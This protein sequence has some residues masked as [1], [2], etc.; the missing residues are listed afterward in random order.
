MKK[1]WELGLSANTKRRLRRG[2]INMYKHLKEQYEEN[3]AW[4]CSL[5]LRNGTRGR[6]HKLKH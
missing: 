5:V 4:L 2:L 6:G 3:G 1:G